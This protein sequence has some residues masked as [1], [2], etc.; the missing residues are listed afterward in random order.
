M[1]STCVFCMWTVALFIQWYFVIFQ[2][3]IDIDSTRKC[4]QV[5]RNPNPPLKNKQYW[6][7]KLE[8]NATAQNMSHLFAVAQAVIIF[9]L[10]QE[11]REF[12]NWICVNI[13]WISRD[14][15]NME[16]FVWTNQLLWVNKSGNVFNAVVTLFRYSS[17]SFG[18]V[19]P[20]YST[21]TVKRSK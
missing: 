13:E 19:F 5:S 21:P 2:P 6:K 8:I 14:I 11:T 3:Q 12:R 16:H 4:V 18:F 20:S 9:S 17:F 7:K 1:N 10:V 15:P